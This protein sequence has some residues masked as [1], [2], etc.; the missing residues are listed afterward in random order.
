[1]KKKAFIYSDAIKNSGIFNFSS[2]NF[3]LNY[4]SKIYPQLMW[5]NFDHVNHIQIAKKEL[6]H[7]NKI[8]PKV[9]RKVFGWR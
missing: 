2:Y 6:G 3:C 9:M 5:E 7:D 4:F 8:S 1:M